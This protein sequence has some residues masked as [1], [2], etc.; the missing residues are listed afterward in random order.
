[1]G[2]SLPSRRC[3]AGRRPFR[4]R[5]QVRS[6]ACLQDLSGGRGTLF[7]GEKIV[8]AQIHTGDRIQAGQT[9]F[10]VLVQGE[11]VPAA[12]RRQSGAPSS[13]RAETD[14]TSKEKTAPD[15]ARPLG[16]GAR[17][18]GAFEGRPAAGRVSGPARW[19]HDLFA[20]AL[21]FSRSGC[22]SRWPSLGVADCLEAVAG[23]RLPPRQQAGLA[24]ARKW[25]AEPDEKNRRKAEAAAENANYEGPAS[26]LAAAAFWSGGSLAPA[27]PCRSSARGILTAQ[28]VSAALLMAGTWG[29]PLNLPTAIGV[30]CKKE[31]SWPQASNI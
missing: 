4:H 1:M 5:L 9:T 20:E 14:P 31:R 6:T 23:D 19:P 10:S 2:R 13:R 18:P 29:D 8:E 28:A 24:Q 7:N 25:S 21:R 11:P 26:F 12:E 3:V 22:P 30:S 17:G 27:G 15:Y 16:L